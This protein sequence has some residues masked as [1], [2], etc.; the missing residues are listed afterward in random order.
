MVIYDA[1]IFH[2]QLT[3]GGRRE[4]QIVQTLLETGGVM[5]SFSSEQ[6]SKNIE[7]KRDQRVLKCSLI[8]T[9]SVLR[10]PEVEIISPMCQ[11]GNQITFDFS[12]PANYNE[13]TKHSDTAISQSILIAS[14]DQEMFTPHENLS[15]ETF[16]ETHDVADDPT[17][18]EQEESLPIMSPA[19]K[20]TAN[21]EFKSNDSAGKSPETFVPGLRVT[22]V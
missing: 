11:S 9:T 17:I 8:A 13:I 19:I 6:S 15:R 14:S 16:P 18:E 2:G 7:V 20:M 22:K 4:K 1:T 5:A 3:K 21:S 10:A 12:I